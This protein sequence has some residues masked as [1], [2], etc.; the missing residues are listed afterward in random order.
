MKKL[1]QV[2]MLSCLFTNLYASEN[3]FEEMLVNEIE[4]SNYVLNDND[5]A[6]YD[7]MLKTIRVRIRLTTGI[8][9]PGLAS[10]KIR[11]EI[12]LFYTK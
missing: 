10:A 3:M 5:R 11:P 9:F 2:I 8:N 7:W 6:N 4:K 1:I 12:E